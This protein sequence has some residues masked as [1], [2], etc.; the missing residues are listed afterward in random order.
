M[1][2]EAWM[3]EQVR[4]EISD[5][6]RRFGFEQDEAVAYWHLRQAAELIFA[7]KE[8]DIAKDL[9]QEERDTIPY[10]EASALV[11]SE[12]AAIQA[13]IQQHFTALYRELGVRVLRRNFPEGWGGDPIADEDEE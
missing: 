3:N 10:A 12:V 7:L 8:V 9:R 2:H 13:G 6:R 1:E 11:S 4:G 5:L